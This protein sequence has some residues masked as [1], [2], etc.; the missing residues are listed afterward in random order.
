MSLW[1]ALEALAVPAAVEAEWRALLGADFGHARPF[2]RATGRRAESYPRPDGGEPYAVVEHG[3][4]DTVGVDPDTGRSVPLSV[5]QVAVWGFD[6]PRLLAAVAA[7]LGV[8]PD[9]RPEPA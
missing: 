9:P 5:G 7:A 3:P 6:R 8:T 2:L 1:T 4:G